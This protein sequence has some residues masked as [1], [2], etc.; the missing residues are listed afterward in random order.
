MNNPHLLP[1]NPH[2]SGKTQGSPRCGP[3]NPREGPTLPSDAQMLRSKSSLPQRGSS[4]R[5]SCVPRAGSPQLLVGIRSPFHKTRVKKLYVSP[6]LGGRIGDP[7]MPQ[8]PR[9][10]ALLLFTKPPWPIDVREV[11]FSRY[12]TRTHSRFRPF[13]GI[14]VLLLL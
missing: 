13:Y 11:I 8:L 5:N 7:Q 6:P 14:S 12:L 4:P 3:R 10:I 1:A 9:A 2:W